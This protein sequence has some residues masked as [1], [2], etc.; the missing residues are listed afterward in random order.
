MVGGL[1][2]GRERKVCTYFDCAGEVV[3]EGVVVGVRSVRFV[4]VRSAGLHPSV[5]SSAIHAVPALI[6]LRNLRRVC[7]VFKSFS[8][9][10]LHVHLVNYRSFD[11]PPER[12]LEEVKRRLPDVSLGMVVNQIG[13]MLA[14][15]AR[16]V[17]ATG[18]FTLEISPTS[19]IQRLHLGMIIGAQGARKP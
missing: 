17:N 5:L 2:S 8:R 15:L 16:Q 12:D 3:V 14:A 7:L 6:A 9:P 1:S 13:G 19:I 18:G 11:R 10:R 4:G